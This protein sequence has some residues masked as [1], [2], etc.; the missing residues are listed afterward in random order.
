MWAVA[1]TSW[2]IANQ[3]LSESIS[4]P[5]ITSG[6]SIVGKL[7]LVSSNMLKKKIIEYGRLFGGKTI[8]PAYLET[9]LIAKSDNLSL[10]EKYKLRLLQGISF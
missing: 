9:I 2:F 4:F 10:V 3:A 5:I 8:L 7:F 6:P 1:Q